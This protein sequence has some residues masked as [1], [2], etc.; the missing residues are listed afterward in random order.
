MA[1]EAQY[2]FF[3]KLYDE[4]SE[5]RKN[6]QERS[7]FYFT[8]VSFY[9]GAMLFKLQDIV[10]AQPI[11]RLETIFGILSA[12]IISVS[13]LF[14]LLAIRVRAYETPC[15]PEKW[16]MHLGENPQDDPEFFD[17]R[18]VDLAV[19]TK[20]NDEVNTAA[21]TKIKIAGW[22]IFGAVV[23]QLVGLICLYVFR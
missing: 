18:I 6:I 9:F 11:P 7:K 10:K 5:R 1:T 2:K 16:I 17:E 4:Q 21:A 20:R 12:V 15:D 23:V 3:Q 8:V 13:L 14:T 22:L 19:A